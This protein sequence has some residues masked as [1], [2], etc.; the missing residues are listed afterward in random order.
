VYD[1]TKTRVDSTTE[2]MFVL[3]LNHLDKLCAP[4][5][6]RG[7]VRGEAGTEEVA[8]TEREVELK[9]SESADQDVTS[10][11]SSNSNASEDR[12]M[13]SPDPEIRQSPEQVVVVAEANSVGSDDP[14]AANDA[15]KR[16]DAEVIDGVVVMRDDKPLEVDLHDLTF[17]EWKELELD[18]EIVTAPRKLQPIFWWFELTFDIHPLWL[19]DER[20]CTSHSPSRWELCFLF[21]FSLFVLFL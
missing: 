10:T 16:S 12:V 13:S 17:D 14:I 1:W 21:S 4:G 20:N 18:G 9:S 15:Q 2:N 3:L 6:H 8:A 5:V 7:D 11:D 19:Q